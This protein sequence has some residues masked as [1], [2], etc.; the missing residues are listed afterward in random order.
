MAKGIAEFVCDRMCW[1]DAKLW[2]KGEVLKCAEENADKVS[3][4]FTRVD[5][6]DDTPATINVDETIAGLT[7]KQIMSILDAKGIEYPSK[8]N[9]VTLLG[10]LELVKEGVEI[11]KKEEEEE[12]EEG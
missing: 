2:K 12:E 5:K 7:N 11:P 3:R 1:F 10:L 8:A 6:V 9:R 4:H